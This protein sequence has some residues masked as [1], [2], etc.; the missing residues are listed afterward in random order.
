MGMRRKCSDYPV[1]IA[2]MREYPRLR[3]QFVCKDFGIAVPTLADLDL[4]QANALGF[5]ASWVPRLSV[6][7]SAAHPAWDAA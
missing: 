1:S 7:N 5:F 3:V 4:K 2:R 6:R